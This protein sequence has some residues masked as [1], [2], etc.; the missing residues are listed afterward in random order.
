M[1]YS[2][3]LNQLVIAVKGAGEMA[4]GVAWRL[5]R[6]GF[7]KIY[8]LE[9]PQPLAVRRQV[10][11]S[12]AVYDGKAVVEGVEAH[13]VSSSAGIPDVWEN[14]GI[15]VR[16]DPEWQSLKQHRPQV[17]VDAIIA[18]KNLGTHMD[19][20]GLVIG[21]GPG[22]TAG[23]DVHLAVETN[24]GHN[25][26]RLIT[27]GCPQADTGIPGAIAGVTRARLLRAPCRGTFISDLGIASPVKEG[28]TV[29]FIDGTP[30]I[31]GVDGVLRGQIRSG[32]HVRKG[33]KIGDIDPRGRAEYCPTIS[34][35]ARAIGGSV[36]EAVLRTYNV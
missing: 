4:T 1:G 21:L 6:S 14:G 28:D 16:V 2:E 11:F 17:V 24:R 26:G 29:G 30:V 32:I 18:K 31:A 3:P 27:R 8:M 22:F 13:R 20:A 10:C 25:L 23:E 9:S 12:E 35:K 36:L 5:F 33:C 19:E 15:P 7:K 34:E